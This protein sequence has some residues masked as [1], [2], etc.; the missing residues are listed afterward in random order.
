MRLH[1]AALFTALCAA[2]LVTGAGAVTTSDWT[3]TT[4][5]DFSGKT[6]SVVV[7]DYGELRLSR[8]AT[9][10]L[11]P[12]ADLDI[13]YA[14]VCLPDGSLIIA[15]GATGSVSKIEGKTRRDLY[16]AGPNAIVTSLALTGKGQILAGISGAGARLVGI[17]PASGKATDIYKSDTIQ[18]IWAI[19]PMED[20]SVLLGT[21]PTGQLL[22]VKSDGTAK[23]VLQTQQK[24]ILSILP[25]A[26]D[27]VVIGTDPDGLV[28]RVNIAS[29][30]WFV[31]YDAKEPEI[32]SLALAADGSI[33]VAA[34]SPVEAPAPATQGA[35]PA[36]RELGPD[37]PHP[38]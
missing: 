29:G 9:P 23:V 18:F 22:R 17:D 38:S 19:L 31:L 33:Y 7:S 11:E 8:G 10:V 24:N 13:V 28:M 26:P 21:G 2:L 36:R 37:V 27:Q 12:G 30:D 4:K 16:S 34:S 32:V 15:T 35:A 3:H 6:D 1:A 5:A 20:G 14:S 25:Q